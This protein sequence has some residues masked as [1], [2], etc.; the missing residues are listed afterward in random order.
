MPLIRHTVRATAGGLRDLA[1]RP[2]EEIGAD[3]PNES[4]PK[5]G[6]DFIA[7]WTESEYGVIAWWNTE[8]YVASQSTF[9]DSTVFTGTRW[10]N[11]FRP[12]M[13]ERS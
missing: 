1:P 10:E 2:W 12:L 3:L 13:R 9:G 8:F 7:P 5:G 6:G 11:R 4:C